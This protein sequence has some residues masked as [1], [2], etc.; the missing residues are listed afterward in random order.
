MV[1]RFPTVIWAAQHGHERAAAIINVQ[2]RFLMARSPP[3]VR[4]AITPEGETELERNRAMAE[5]IFA[6]IAAINARHGGGPAPQIVRAMENLKLA[7][8]LRLSQGPLGAAMADGAAMGV[9]AVTF[10]CADGDVGAEG[11]G[12]GGQG[13]ARGG[14]HGDRLRCGVD[15]RHGSGDIFHKI[16]LTR[17][18]AGGCRRESVD[19]EGI[20]KAYGGDHLRLRGTN[21][22]CAIQI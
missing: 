11:V 12:D 17:G 19:G 1:S 21:R 6:R 13:T 3:P 4:H 15:S 5:E 22:Q 7:L 14:L 18:Q 8:R 2:I 10:V 16:E 20:R 9:C